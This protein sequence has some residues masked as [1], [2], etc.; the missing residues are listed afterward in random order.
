MS[1]TQNGW[2]ALPPGSTTLHTWR[3]PART[4]EV[5]LLMRNGSA[6]FVLA[7]LALWLAETV[8]PLA[9]KVRDDW[10]YA[11][12][13]IRGYE[14]GLSNHA[15]GTALDLNATRHPLGKRG[16]W[17]ARQ[18]ALIRHRLRMRLYAGAIRWGGDYAGRPDEMH[19]ELVKPLPVVE[20]VARA[21][22]RTRRGRRLLAANPGQRAVILS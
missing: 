6:G 8:T 16:T 1:T 20:T 18:A 7:H 22:M 10:G 12:R 19:V 5:V 14:T 9:G 17:P 2:P 3:I 21:L 15:S 4:G 11:W 13:P